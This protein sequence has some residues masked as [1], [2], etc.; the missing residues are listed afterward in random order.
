MT[1]AHSKLRTNARRVFGSYL[2][3]AS[4]VGLGCSETTRIH[5]V[6]PGA[7]V[8]V[9]DRE[10]GEAPV[11]FK[12]KSWSVRPNAYRYRVEK[13]GYLSRDGYLQ[14]HLST[15]RIIAA[16]LSS[17]FTCSFHGFFEFDPE[18][19][20]RLIPDPSDGTAS[21]TAE[22]TA[23]RLRVLRD[24]HDQGLITDEEFREL[25]A[26]ILRATFGDPTAA[27]DAQPDILRQLLPGVAR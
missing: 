2:L 18:I 11:K 16:A 21:P 23:A 17:C 6:P 3:V 7:T 8:R 26:T 1:P 25:K 20:I 13:P 14:P 5:T 27:P 19:Q 10:L 9:N 12:A 22:S 24:Y 4:A 15:G